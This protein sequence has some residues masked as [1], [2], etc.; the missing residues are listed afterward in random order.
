M[1]PFVYALVC[2][3]FWAACLTWPKFFHDLFNF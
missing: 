1:K 3:L 2:V